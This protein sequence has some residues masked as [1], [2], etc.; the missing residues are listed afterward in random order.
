MICRKSDREAMKLEEEHVY[1]VR[2]RLRGPS[3]K[4]PVGRWAQQN[5]PDYGSD[6]G[7]SIFSTSR[8]PHIS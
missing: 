5:S 6:L 2:R 1:Q 7:F 4:E 3:E 8:N